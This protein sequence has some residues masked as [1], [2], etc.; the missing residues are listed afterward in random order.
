MADIEFKTHRI[1]DGYFESPR[2]CD[3]VAPDG[4]RSLVPG[5]FVA[6]RPEG[7]GIRPRVGTCIGLWDGLV[8][9]MWLPWQQDPLELGARAAFGRPPK[10]VK[11]RRA[12]V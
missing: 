11:A 6:M 7:N 10:R 1:I 2:R 4:S 3:I 8:Y 5:A 9:M 12:Q